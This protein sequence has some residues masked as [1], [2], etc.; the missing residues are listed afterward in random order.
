MNTAFSPSPKLADW[1]V[2][3]RAAISETNKSIIPQRIAE[4]QKA[5]LARER[6]IFYGHGTAEEG[7]ALE[8][9]MYTLR[10]FRTALQHTKAA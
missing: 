3:Y 4:A 7:E 6:E 5:V 10:A 8:D 9:A 1:K 2:L